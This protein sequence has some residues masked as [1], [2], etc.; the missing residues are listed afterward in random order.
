MFGIPIEHLIPVANFIGLGLLG[1]LAWFGQR[2]GQRQVTPAEKQIEVAG[3]LVDSTSVRQLTAAIEALNVQYAQNRADADRTRKLGHELV[4][5][6]ESVA[7]ELGEV[8]R[9]MQM[10]RR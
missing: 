4:E 1:L 9:E 5:A 3:A 8:R 7:R 6:M 10:R 2:W